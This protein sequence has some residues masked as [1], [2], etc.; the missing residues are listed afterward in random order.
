VGYDINQEY[1]KLAERRIKEFK[2]N[3][4]VPEL[5]NFVREGKIKKAK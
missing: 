2:L 3:F 1:V 5:F 4:N